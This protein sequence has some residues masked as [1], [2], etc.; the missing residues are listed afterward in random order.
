MS[1]FCV[2]GAIDVQKN[3]FVKN[4]FFAWFTW[5]GWWHRVVQRGCSPFHA[6]MYLWLYI[7]RGPKVTSLLRA[8][9]VAGARNICMMYA[10]YNDAHRT[11]ILRVTFAGHMRQIDAG[12]TPDARHIL[13][14]DANVTHTCRTRSAQQGMLLLDPLCN[15]NVNRHQIVHR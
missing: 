12:F 2:I 1:I 6:Y 5:V 8:P 14:S 11:R 7:Q 9:R 10:G 3:I 15:V 4:I 13:E